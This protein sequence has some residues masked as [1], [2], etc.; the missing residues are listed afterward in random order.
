MRDRLYRLAI[1]WTKRHPFG[2]ACTALAALL[3][4]ASVWLHYDLEELTVRQTE[5]AREGNTMLVMIARGAQ[6]RSELT[7]TRAAT[8]RITENLVVEKNIPDNFWYFYKIEQDTDA[9]LVELQQHPALLQESGG[10]TS[11]KQVPYSLKFSGSFPAVI[12]A[13]QR[14]ETG[15]RLGRI[16]ALRLQRGDPASGGVVLQLDFELLGF[17]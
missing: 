16:D 14:L 2:A 5:L 15:P 11:Y 1:Q 3:A 12:S 13:L 4:G 8:Q 7:A 17:P 9:R 6:L 10:P